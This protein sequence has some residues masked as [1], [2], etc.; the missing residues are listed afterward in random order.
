M[1]DAIKYVTPLL[2]ISA[3]IITIDQYVKKGSYWKMWALTT[4]IGCFIFALTFMIGPPDTVSSGNHESRESATPSGQG[5]Q[6]NNSPDQGQMQESP[7]NNQQQAKAQPGDPQQGT[8]QTGSSEQT[9]GPEQTTVSPRDLFLPVDEA[10]LDA[11][12]KEFRD[13]FVSA[14]NSKDLSFLTSH[15][16]PTIRYSFGIN[17]GINGFLSHWQLDINPENSQIWS[18]LAQVLTLGGS[19]DQEKAVFTAPYVFANFPYTVDGFENV[20]VIN[21]NVS[22]HSDPDPNSPVLMGLSY[23]ILK[24]ADSKIYKSTGVTL[25]DESAD[26]RK[27]VT[28]SGDGYVN[29]VYVRSPIDYRAQFRQEEGQWKMIFFVAGD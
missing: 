22:I 23:K 21:Q 20:A 5:A 14:V 12:F 15:L 27:V 11:D 17:N 2:L 26:W 1:W 8:G 16:S 28:S 3:V 10:S 4:F 19:F 25:P 29:E 9:T 6:K 7:Q 24:L 18:E 13:G